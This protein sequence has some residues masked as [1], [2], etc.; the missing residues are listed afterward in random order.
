MRKAFNRAFRLV[1]ALFGGEAIEAHSLALVLRQATTTY[2]VHESEVRLSARVPLV[3]GKLVEAHGISVVL[4]Q[5]AAAPLV[6]G[7]EAGLSAR[8]PLAGGKLVEAH[9]FCIGFDTT[10]PRQS[11]SELKYYSWLVG[12]SG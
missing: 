4:R 11:V 12:A 5:A 8:V 1:I 10:N 7:S 9:S 6:H 3:G 2:F